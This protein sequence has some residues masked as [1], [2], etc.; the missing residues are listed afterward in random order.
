MAPARRQLGNWNTQECCDIDADERLA[1]SGVYDIVRL[2]YRFP[3]LVLIYS[4][5]Q[6]VSFSGD[7]SISLERSVGGLTNWQRLSF[8]PAVIAADGKI[9]P[10]IIS[11]SNQFFRLKIEPALSGVAR[12]EMIFIQGGTNLGSILDQQTNRTTGQSVGSFYLSKYEVTWDEWKTVRAWA[13]ING[14]DLTNGIGQGSGGDHPVREVSWYD[15]LKWCNAKSETEGLTPAYFRGGSIFRTGNLVD[16]DSQTV[17]WVTNANGYRLPSEAEWEYAARGGIY[18]AGNTYSGI[19]GP[20]ALTNAAWIGT[21]S[22]G[23]PAPI[24]NGQGTWPVGLKIPNELGIYDMSGN[25][26]EWVWDLLG[27][28]QTQRV[29]RGGGWESNSGSCRNFYGGNGGEPTERFADMG[30]RAARSAQ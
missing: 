16:G 10:P 17:T 9:N 5:L 6:S 26:W 25:I 28:N 4:A 30:F 27:D 15:A 21:N 7:L 20:R 18:N 22:A 2:V 8:S 23:C 12:A 19:S 11:A 29:Q 13:T 14:Y 24:A 1:R 3:C